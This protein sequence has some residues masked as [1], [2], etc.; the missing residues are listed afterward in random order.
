MESVASKSELF[1]SSQRIRAKALADCRK[2]DHLIK[3]LILTPGGRPL[4]PLMLMCHDFKECFPKLCS[5]AEFIYDRSNTKE[6]G[7][8]KTTILPQNNSRPDWFRLQMFLKSNCSRLYI[9]RNGQY[10]DNINRQPKIL[11]LKPYF[12]RDTLDISRRM[13]CSVRPSKSKARAREIPKSCFIASLGHFI[14]S[15]T[16]TNYVYS[17]LPND[18]ICPLRRQSQDPEF[19][20]LYRTS[21][22]G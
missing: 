9:I 15:N 19:F 11:T 6:C 5:E 13:S 16:C 14:S 4:H 8:K 10:S 2:T 3:K 18:H 21:Y 20:W 22:S 1:P 12:I 17:I 7:L